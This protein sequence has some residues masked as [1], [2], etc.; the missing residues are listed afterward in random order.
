MTFCQ[1]FMISSVAKTRQN[2]IRKNIDYDETGS[3]FFPLP[4]FFPQ[5][6][7]EMGENGEMHVGDV[8]R[9]GES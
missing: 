2:D 4:P 8:I 5:L 9:H 3:F 1:N 7:V 6:Q